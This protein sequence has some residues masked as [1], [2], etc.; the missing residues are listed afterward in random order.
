[1]SSYGALNLAAWLL[2]HG[3]PEGTALVE[4]EQV[5]SFADLGVRVRKIAGVIRRMTRPATRP[6]V[7]ILAENSIDQVATYLGAL[8]AGVVASPLAPMSQ[9]SLGDI[10]KE[11]AAPLVFVDERHRAQLNGMAGPRVVSIEGR[12]WEGE[13]ASAA[14][15]AVNP[16]E[17][18]LLLYTSGSTGRPR[19]VKLSSENVRFNTTAINGFLKLGV[20]DRAL[21]TLPF[22]YCYGASVLHTHLRVGASVALTEVLYPDA[23]L[24]ELE[25]TAAT[26][27]PGVPSLFHLILGRSAV[28]KRTSPRL[29]Y[30]MS[31][32]G[33][34]PETT[35]RDLEQALPGVRIFARYGVTES[36][37]A[38]SYLPPERLSDKIGSIGRGLDEAPLSVERDDGT[39]VEP[40]REIGE[41]VLRGAHV[42]MGYFQSSGEGDGFR[43]GAFH[44]GDLARA[45]SEGFI[46]IVG[47]A[48]EFIKTAGHRVAPQEVEDIIAEIPGVLESGVCGV[49]HPERG[50]ALFAAVVT[51]PGHPLSVET[52]RRHCRARLPAFKVPVDF[53]LVDEL[54][55]TTNGKISRAGL[56]RL[57][58]KEGVLQ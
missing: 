2:E 21:V 10:L 52:L 8:Y 33:A 30:I 44:T 17:V 34:M 49:P 16:K 7:H 50:E 58:V 24:D 51:G 54:P 48:K 12:S 26:G 35:L 13:D 27:L 36:T 45:D 39:P 31:S 28:K 11:T 42:S 57:Q 5:V 47:R 37:A 55:K 6:V 46:F 56:A 9:R 43:N 53:I 41:I 40:G 29:R 1:M 18:A 4:G 23:L 14:P 15:E 22:S 19:G 32:G 38:A 20:D 3:R 25:R